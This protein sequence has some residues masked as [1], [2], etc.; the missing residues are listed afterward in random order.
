MRWREGVVMEKITA[1]YKADDLN[2]Y[3]IEYRDEQ[4][5]ISNGFISSNVKL[6]VVIARSE[7]DA[8]IVFLKKHG[9]EIN[10]D[11]VANTKILSEEQ[12]AIKNIESKTRKADNDIKAIEAA[13]L[14]IIDDMVS[15][16]LM[17]ESNKRRSITSLAMSIT[18]LC[19]SVAAF[20]IS[21][22]CSLI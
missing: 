19:F 7:C 21:L 15:I 1:A 5:I 20:V 17:A 4:E 9:I 13:H 8:V 12:W 22:I 11:N 10:E 3:H 16:L 18:A 6:D 2:T 14:K